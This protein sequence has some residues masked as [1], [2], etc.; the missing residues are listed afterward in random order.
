MKAEIK[1]LNE[2]FTSN[3]PKLSK[4]VPNPKHDTDIRCFEKTMFLSD[5]SP[6]EVA[7]IIKKNE[8]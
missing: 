1:K 4:Q 7:P 3:A 8:K 5:T 2:V 6:D